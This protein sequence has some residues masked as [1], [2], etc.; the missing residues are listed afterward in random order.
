MAKNLVRNNRL[1]VFLVNCISP[2]QPLVQRVP[3]RQF[4]FLFNAL[5]P[6]NNALIDGVVVWRAWVICRDEC[7][8]LLRAPIVTLVLAIF[9]VVATICVRIFINI[10]PVNRDKG[11]LADIIAVLQGIAYTFSLLTNILGT[12]IISLKAW[13]SHDSWLCTTSLTLGLP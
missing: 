12:G 11:R 1:H 5:V 9:G 7:R 6:I 13:Y 10:D 8:K 4:W 2:S 3:R